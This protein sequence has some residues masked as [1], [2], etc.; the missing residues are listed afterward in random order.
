MNSEQLVERG[1]LDDL[2]RQVDRLAERREWDALIDLRDRCRMALQRGKQLWAVAAHIE[3]RVALE[4][5]GDW[6]ARMVSEG[7]GRFSFGPLPEVAAS[8]HSW[9][10]L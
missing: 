10:E 3:Y 8:T 5:P 6:A 9:S 7:G 1:D 2:T 4:A